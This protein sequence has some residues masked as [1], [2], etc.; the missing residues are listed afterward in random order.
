MKM[1]K[2]FSSVEHPNAHTVA[3]DTIMAIYVSATIGVIVYAIWLLLG[4][5]FG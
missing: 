3:A 2:C 4:E 1:L 5:I